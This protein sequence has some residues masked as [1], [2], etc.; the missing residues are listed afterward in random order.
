MIS[1]LTVNTEPTVEPVTLAQVKLALRLDANDSTEDD[2]LDILIETARRTLE[3]W[4]N[5]TFVQTTYILY[6]DVNPAQLPDQTICLQRPPI[7][8]TDP[9]TSIQYVD[10]SGDTQTVDSSVYTVDNKSEPGRIVL[11]FNQS[12]PASRS[13]IQQYLVTYL[14]GYEEA[15]DVADIPNWIRQV[16]YLLISNYYENREPVIVGSISTELELSL[17]SLVWAHRVKVF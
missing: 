2:Y 17:N 8:A 12:W 1:H 16:M 15:D 6:L 3:I 14:A 4:M 11:A 10:N 7:F 5:R 13:Q 9:V